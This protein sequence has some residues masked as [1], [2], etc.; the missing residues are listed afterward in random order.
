MRY[1]AIAGCIRAADITEKPLL[2]AGLEALLL[3]KVS[4]LLLLCHRL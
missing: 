4:L 3:V 2:L 1:T